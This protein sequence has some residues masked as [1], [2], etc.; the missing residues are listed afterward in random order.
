MEKLADVLNRKYPQFNT[1]SPT[2]TVRDGLYKMYVENVDFLIVLDGSRF[3][4]VLTEHEVVS[5]ILLEE[6]SLKD[7]LVKDFMNTSLPC[8][9][10]DDSI[11]YGMQLME[12]HNAR[13]LVL[14]D[15]FTFKGIVSLQD[16]MRETL[17]KRSAVFE[18]VATKN[19]YP[20]NY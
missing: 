6:Q 1:I 18:E 11:E 13:Y 3:F 19:A 8:A 14:Y 7:V 15:Q 10:T 2:D 16:L 17:S 5:K 20:W 9:T 12:H 4:G